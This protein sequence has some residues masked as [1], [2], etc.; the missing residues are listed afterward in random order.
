MKC[1]NIYNL[2]IQMIDCFEVYSTIS[3]KAMTSV[4]F[5]IISPNNS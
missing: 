2:L 1:V 5:R 3:K 4:M